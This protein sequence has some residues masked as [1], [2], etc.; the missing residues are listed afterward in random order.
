MNAHA[1]D[2]LSAFGVEE[3]NTEAA[4]RVEGGIPWAVIGWGAVGSLVAHVIVEIIDDTAAA[5]A[6][7]MEGFNATSG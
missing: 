2:N 5:G 1:I 6:A 3:M 7:F 4:D